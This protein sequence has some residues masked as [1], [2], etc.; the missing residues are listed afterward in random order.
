MYTDATIARFWQKV[1]KSDGCWEWTACKGRRDYGLFY[2]GKKLVV[3]HRFAWEI[4]NGPIPD[5]L[6]VCHQCDNTKCVRPDHLWLG[7]HEQNM[8]DRNDKGRS[9][10]GERHVSRT[11]PEVLMRGDTHYARTEPERLARGEQHGMTTL[12]AAQVI[13][14]REAYGTGG[15]SY[16]ELAKRYSV[17]RGTICNIVR[18]KT[19]K[20]VP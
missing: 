15:P 3:A 6:F 13:A 11:H 9:A 14:I 12:T 18:R 19:W 17:D 2:N 20:H 5:G 10:S 8:T 7:T 16:G 1:S 4:T